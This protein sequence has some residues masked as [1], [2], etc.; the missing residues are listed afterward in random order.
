MNP[1]DLTED[2]R[3][4]LTCAALGMSNKATEAET[5]ITCAGVH[6]IQKLRYDLYEKLGV[7]T[8]IQ[9]LIWALK[10]NVVTL[11]YNVQNQNPTSRRA[12]Q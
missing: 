9:A 8:T 1:T 7:H 10:N 2:E 5:F 4:L 6:E 3:K 11:S 12:P